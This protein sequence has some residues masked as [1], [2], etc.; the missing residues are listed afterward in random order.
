MTRSDIPNLITVLR[1]LLV[2]PIVYLIY[3]G[4]FD[5]ALL[6]FLGAGISD[7]LDG[8]LAKHYGWSS[9]LGGLLDPIAD[10][11]LLVSSYVVLAW[12]QLIPVWLVVTVILRDLI[13]LAGAIT[14]HFRIEALSATPSVISKLNTLSQILLVVA[15]IFSE[16]FRALPP[17]WLEFLVY[18]V[19]ATTLL[20]GVDYVWT[21]GW[22]AWN[23]KR[24]SGR[25][26]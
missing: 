16:G 21:W 14:Y 23:K 1:I 18:M 17:E 8:F 10:K 7:A 4:A 2:P 12:A 11:A 26:P 9:R 6:L 5:I 22:R 20:S 19:L 13:I 24:G 25:F 15:V 3:E